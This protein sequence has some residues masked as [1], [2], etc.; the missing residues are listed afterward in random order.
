MRGFQI[1]GEIARRV[2]SFL[3]PRLAPYSSL[4]PVGT[5]RKL[6]FFGSEGNSTGSAYLRQ[7]QLFELASK[8]A[9]TYWAADAD[10]L[11]PYSVVVGVKGT[12]EYLLSAKL[13]CTLPGMKFYYDPVDQ[14]VD[15]SRLAAVDGVVASSY[16]QYLWLRSTLS[17]PVFLLPHHADLRINSRVE[18]TV[19]FLVGYFGVRK[20]GFLPEAVASRVAIVDVGSCSDIRWMNRLATYP[21][22]YCVRRKAEK[23]HSYKPATKLFIAAKVGA[24]VITT[25]DES[26]AELLLPPDYPFFSPSRNERAVIE[27]IEFARESYGTQLFA[28]AVADVSRVPGWSE[29]EQCRQLLTLLSLG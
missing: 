5:N 9:Q 4:A 22:H 3:T 13:T 17:I 27:T 12:W 25:R 2:Q 7:G 14:L 11:Q 6:C 20:N 10:S 16:R 15:P 19:P 23:S 24:A 8:V 21:C 1:R 29:P 28:K 26:D 18:P